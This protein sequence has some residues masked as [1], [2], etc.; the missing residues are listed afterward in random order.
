MMMMILY[1][2]TSKC[3]C[4]SKTHCTLYINFR[5]NYCIFCVRLKHKF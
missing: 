3:G 5:V 2:E 1:T 4:Y